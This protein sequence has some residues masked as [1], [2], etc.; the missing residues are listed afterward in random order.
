MFSTIEVR[1]RTWR[2]LDNRPG[3]DKRVSIE[4][5]DY[6]RYWDSIVGPAGAAILRTFAE[7]PTNALVEGERRARIDADDLAELIGVKLTPTG[8]FQKLR[9]L[10]ALQLGGWEPH[11]NVFTRNLFVPRV[12]L[13]HALK[14]GP[15][16]QRHERV[17]WERH[18]V[19]M[20]MT[21]S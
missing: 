3:D 11:A 6:M 15:D 17:A 16:W 19:S 13:T 2:H 20:T 4:C 18:H 12:P 1:D 5:R 14:R 7:L 10:G 9:R 8:V 21:S